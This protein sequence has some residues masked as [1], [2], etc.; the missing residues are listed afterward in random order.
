MQH[1][2]AQ[3]LLIVY[4]FFNILVFSKNKRFD[5][6]SDAGGRMKSVAAL[7][8]KYWQ[9]STSKHLGIAF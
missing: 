4:Q 3:N 1:L 2:A 8:T 6:E 5:H 9:A 7:V